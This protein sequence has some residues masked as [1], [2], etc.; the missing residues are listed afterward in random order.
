M[1]SHEII[2]YYKYVAIADPEAFI[3]S[4]RLLCEQLNLKGRIIVAKEGINGTLEGLKKNIDAYCEALVSDGRF[5][6][7]NFKRSVGNGKAFPKLSIKV[8][9]E[10]VTGSLGI[11]D[12]NPQEMTGEYLSAEELH[13]WIQNK[14]DFA[15]VDM[16][17]DYEHKVGYFENSIL[18]PL[19][20]FR[21][22][23]K[24]IPQLEHLKNK[25]VVAVCTGG[26]RCE[27]A[28]GYLV[29]KGFKNVYQLHNGIVT[30]MEKYPTG[31]FKGSLYVFDDRIT[32]AFADGKERGIVGRCDKCQKPSESY[33]NCFN[34]LCHR[35]FICC[36]GCRAGEENVFCGEKCKEG[37]SVSS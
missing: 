33:V 35:H 28:S 22:L 10:I 24:V 8:R 19:T 11:D 36:E 18:P 9:K 29:K 2:L 16:R 13:S 21:D 34:N 26:V 31:A 4:Q 6:G 12:V 37:I 32:M 20:N 1:D 30:Y 27:K 5:V 14:E 17:N 15:I 3:K 23:P 25:K 7:I